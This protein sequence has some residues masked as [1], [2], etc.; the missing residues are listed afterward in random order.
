MPARTRLQVGLTCYG[1]S[2]EKRACSEECPR[3]FGLKDPA[4][5]ARCL[6]ACDQKY[7]TP[8]VVPCSIELE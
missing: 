1:D 4:G 7:P 6:E 3:K 8:V 5:N 2:P